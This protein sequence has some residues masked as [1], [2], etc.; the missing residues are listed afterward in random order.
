M[1]P[2]SIIMPDLRNSLGIGG[3]EGKEG[4]IDV[5]FDQLGNTTMKFEDDWQ[6]VLINREIT[7]RWRTTFVSLIFWK[8][9]S[10]IDRIILVIWYQLRR[11]Y[12]ST[13]DWNFSI[14][15][16]SDFYFDITEIIS[17]YQ[18]YIAIQL[19]VRFEENWNSKNETSW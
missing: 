9:E 13:K 10:S 19:S 16:F 5:E 6:A 14:Y 17:N 11:V 7:Y 8:W 4:Y 15:Q 2:D 3:G 18:V 1:I 12:R